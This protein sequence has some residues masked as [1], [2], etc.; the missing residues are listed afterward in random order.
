MKRA[1]RILS[2]S[3]HP[4]FANAIC[5]HL[6]IELTPAETI[7]FGNENLLVRILDSVREAD[8]FFIQTSCSPVSDL[9]LE[10]FLTLD[11]LKHS[12]AG[13][14][15]AVLPYFP[16][17]RS[18]KKDQ[19]RISIAARLMADLLQTSGAERMLTMEL[20]SPQSQGFFKIPMDQ[21]LATDVFCDYFEQKDLSGYTIVAAGL[22]GKSGKV[23]ALD[24]HPL[25]NRQVRSMAAKKNLANVETIHSDCATGLPDGSVDIALLYD[26]LHGLNE[27]DK[28]LEE[29]YRVLKPGGTLSLSDHHMEGSE[30]IPRI[31]D[32]GWFRLTRKGEKV[33]NFSKEQQAI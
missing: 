30:I 32:T 23:Y 3:S 19:P 16:Y 2:G 29:L 11:A 28:V 22:V 17:V 24:I 1:L 13:K 12:S 31:T 27:P 5:D 25:A 18:D 33:Y 21:L 8:T 4:E 15:T 7:K 26:I 20:H 6:G 9:I 14:I 10:T